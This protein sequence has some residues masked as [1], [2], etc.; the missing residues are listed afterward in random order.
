MDKIEI[1]PVSLLEE[2]R[3]LVEELKAIAG[4]LSLEFGWHYLLDLTWIISALG[5]VCGKQI[6]DAGAGTGVLQ[7]YLAW[8]GATVYSV[9][10]SSRADLPW[11]FRR[12]TQV[13]G[14]RPEDLN[15]PLPSLMN[16]LR[17][18]S[19][20]K[21]RLSAARAMI[22]GLRP[23]DSLSQN[24]TEKREGK[25]WIYN[26]DLHSLSALADNSLDA[27]AALSALEH[28]APEDLPHVVHE[29]LRVIKPG[30]LLLATLGASREQD[31]FHEP[32]QGW[33]Y[34]DATLRRA[35][36]LP[37]NTPSNY[38]RYDELFEALRNCAELRDNLAGFYFRSGDNGMPWGKWDPQ[39]QSVGVLKVKR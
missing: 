11:R 26:C 18:T 2:H 7:W 31:W 13:R 32:S 4:S 17:S 1:L 14:V 15:P 20:G 24:E 39:Y 33:C 16:T 37:E 27:V 9:D 36:N 5:N 28:N 38:N 21:R 22:K 19:G 25:V 3:R 34:C 23:N 35:F 8:H 30:G 12:W 6:M 10:R 29:L